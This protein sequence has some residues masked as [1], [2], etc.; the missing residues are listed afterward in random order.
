MLITQ[1]WI[2][3]C[4]GAG[5]GRMH[6][7]TGSLHPPLCSPSL[8]LPANAS[9]AETNPAS[10]TANPARSLRVPLLA[11]LLLLFYPCS[12][13]SFHFSHP[14]STT[15][16]NGGNIRQPLFFFLCGTAP[17]FRMSDYQAF[18]VLRQTLFAH[19]WVCVGVCV[20]RASFRS[21]RVTAT[22]MC[23]TPQLK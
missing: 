2:S 11:S 16:N 21:M 10:V 13:L 23:V 6:P 9:P 22:R 20:V 18:T 19:V 1:C 17:C 5:L 3:G 8:G 14:T 12:I 7:G 4:R 15:R